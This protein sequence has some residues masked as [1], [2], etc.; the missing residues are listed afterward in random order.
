[1]KSLSEHISQLL[2]ENDCVIVPNFGGFLMRR[3]PA[4]FVE[5]EEMLMPPS[6]ELSFNESL[7]VNDGLLIQAVMMDEG[8]SY[9]AAERKVKGVVRELICELYEKGAVVLPGIGCVQQSMSGALHFTQG[10]GDV[11]SPEYYGLVPLR[12]APVGMPED[13]LISEVQPDQHRKRSFA[14]SF[15]GKCLQYAAAGLVAALAFF[16]SGTTVEDENGYAYE[17]HASLKPSFVSSEKMPVLDWLDGE[18][19][20][21]A[22]V[23][24]MPGAAMTSPLPEVT[25][26]ETPGRAEAVAEKMRFEIIVASFRPTDDYAYFLRELSG[27]GFSSCKAVRGET[28]VRISAVSCATFDEAKARMNEIR[29]NTKFKKAWILKN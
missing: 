12:L 15:A 5:G 20:P 17:S 14:S 3:V 25:D 18:I 4:R 16:A 27:M 26:E 23:A 8:V 1:M 11:V 2:V 19:I 28:T 29:A 7:K 13:A 10:G 21:S 9:P 22:E 24:E 6:A